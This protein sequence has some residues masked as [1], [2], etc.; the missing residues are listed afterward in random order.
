MQ[1]AFRRRGTDLG[2]VAIGPN[3]CR[4]PPKLGMTQYSARWGGGFN[5]MPFPMGH[6]I[7][8]KMGP[9][10]G[11]KGAKMGL[12]ILFVPKLSKVVISGVDAGS[13]GGYCTDIPGNQML[14][15]TCRCGGMVDAGDS[16]SPDGDIVPVRVRPP[17]PI[18]TLMFEGGICLKVLPPF[19]PSDRFGS[20]PSFHAMNIPK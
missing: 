5:H 18:L 14:P 4:E 3:L 19:R 13:E 16:K 20:E 11:V 8:G 15:H 6:W 1:R 12:V 9:L 10:R 7:S 17:V 2:Q